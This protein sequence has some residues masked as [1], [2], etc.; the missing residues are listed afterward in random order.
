M[1]ALLLALNPVP[2][3]LPAQDTE[4]M[5]VRPSTEAE[6]VAEFEATCVTGLYDVETLK[7][8]AAAS[9]RGYSFQDNQARG[10]R[11]WVSPYGS[12]HFLEG[13]AE[14]SDMVPKCNLVSFTRTPVNRRAL[15]TALR[16]MAR[17][18]AARG[19]SELRD[20]DGLGWSWYNAANRPM[21]VKVALDRRTPQ[22]I[23]LVL[24]PIA[25]TRT[26]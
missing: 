9:R 22:Q 15:D 14:S 5:R 24:E 1:I 7:R 10:W 18:R 11:N 21:T 6:A 16:A 17:R 23:V 4:Q 26:R 20:N 2:A 3:A 25:V 12:I 13:A 8:A 19:Y